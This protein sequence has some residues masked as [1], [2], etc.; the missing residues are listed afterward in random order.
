M[1][2]ALCIMCNEYTSCESIVQLDVHVNILPCYSRPSAY[3]DLNNFRCRATAP[4]YLGSQL[5]LYVHYR[6]WLHDWDVTALICWL[7]LDQTSTSSQQVMRCAL[8]HERC[9]FTK[10]SSLRA[11]ISISSEMCISHEGQHSR[12]WT[13]RQPATTM[14]RIICRALARRPS[15]HAC[16]GY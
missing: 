13:S 9:S 15:H 3:I 5:A 11:E 8:H 1:H 2:A 16:R 7:R 10:L 6:H 4:E 14:L 12:A